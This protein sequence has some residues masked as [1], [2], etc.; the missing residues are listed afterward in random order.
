MGFSLI[1]FSFQGMY[2]RESSSIQAHANVLAGEHGRRRK[3]RQ[4][5]GP[6]RPSRASRVQGHGPN[7]QGPWGHGLSPSSPARLPWHLGR[8]P[9]ESLGPVRG[10]WPWGCLPSS[11]LRW[12]WPSAGHGASAIH[13]CL[14]CSAEAYVSLAST[15]GPS[16]KYIENKGVLQQDRQLGGVLPT[17]TNSHAACLPYSHPGM[18]PTLK[19]PHCKLLVSPK[20]TLAGPQAAF[21]REL[22]LQT[23]GQHARQ[24]RWSGHAATHP[25]SHGACVRLSHKGF[26]YHLNNDR[27]HSPMLASNLQHQDGKP[28]P[29]CPPRVA[30]CPG[31][32]PRLPSQHTRPHG[33]VLPH[34]AQTC[35][36]PQPSTPLHTRLCHPGN[37]TTH[38][39]VTQQWFGRQLCK[40]HTCCHTAGTQPLHPNIPNNSFLPLW[41]IASLTPALGSPGHR[42]INLPK[43]GAWPHGIPIDM[44]ANTQHMPSPT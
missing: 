1:L 21:L 17:D 18:L 22:H 42:P 13:C 32:S 37:L 16:E 23:H 40:Y 30:A 15:E 5:R 39:E 8:S 3:G 34:W 35:S 2:L 28:L 24:R 11:E 4:A 36:Q 26:L 19:S 25:Q 41:P 7:K 9:Q 10:L 33:Q 29:Q 31:N 27:V 14:W 38:R 6:Q 12:H 44:A 20:V 43:M